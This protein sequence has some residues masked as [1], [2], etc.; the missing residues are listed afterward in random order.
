MLYDHGERCYDEWAKRRG[1]VGNRG[2]ERNVS[3]E[4]R[5]A[6]IT[7][8]DVS[9]VVL[10]AAVL[11]LA[12]VQGPVLFALVP[13]DVTPN[14]VLVT[15]FLWAGYH[16]I[17]EGLVWAFTTGLLLDLLAFAPLGVHAL[18]LMLVVLAAEPVRQWVFRG[19][20]AWAF[21]A[22]VVAGVLYDTLLLVIGR[23]AGEGGGVETLW[24]LSVARALTDALAATVILPLVL[25]LRRWGANADPA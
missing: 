12:L 1:K 25:W 20:H 6:A 4:G 10:V 23:A 22:V 7:G 24:R 11:L 8:G 15:V 16:D 18:A 17:R 21:L 9:R 5:R 3:V 13:L 19:S 14:L 2:R